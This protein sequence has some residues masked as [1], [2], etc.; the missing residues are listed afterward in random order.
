MK[1]VLTGF[2]TAG[3]TTV[4][5]IIAAKKNYKFYD[6]DQLIEAKEKMTIKE[7]FKLKGEKYFRKIEKEIIMNLLKTKKNLVLATGG[8]SIINKE[9]RNLILEQS[10]SF[11]LDLSPE[12]VLKR[13]KKSKI[14]RPLLA[15]NNKL[16]KVKKLL[17]KRKKYYQQIPI[18]FDSET[19]S[20]IEIADLILAELPEQKIN[21]KIDSKSMAYPVIIESKFKKNSFKK[22]IDKIKGNKVF[23]LVDQVLMSKHSAQIIDLLNKNSQL[24]KLELKAGEEIKSL[25][26]LNQ[27]YQILYENNFSRSDYLIAFGGGTVGDLGGLAASTYLRGLKLIQLPTTIISQ[28]DSSI[29][30][31]TAV[32]FKNTKNII[33]T[34][35]QPELVYYQLDWLKTLATREIKSGLGEVIKYSILA[36]PELFDLL[37]EKETEIINLDED[38]MLQIAEIC[39]NTKYEYVRNDVQDKGLRKKL[40]L[41]HSFGHALEA[42]ENF[43]YKHGQ[44]VVMGIAF[45]AFLSNKIG[46]LESDKFKKIIKLILNFNYEIF[47][48][49]AI[50]VKDLIN[51]LA[52]DKKNSGNKIWWV[53]INDIGTTYLSDRFKQKELSQYMEEYLCKKWLLSMDLI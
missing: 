9:L 22:I 7:I 23:L 47:P 32:N 31:K 52:Y 16:N 51:Y 38:I 11:C 21:I 12:A 30:G 28:L 3:K 40:N 44:A 35:Y 46:V 34:F 20:A 48:S 45:T 6:S 13:E 4:A 53:L 39:L 17:A 10:E 36:G 14:Q 5:K 50:K 33:G 49:P 8:G 19:N 15:G 42:T 1:I 27:I 18:H 25:S 29:G 2:M 41:G 24:V 43:N 37:V 26:Y